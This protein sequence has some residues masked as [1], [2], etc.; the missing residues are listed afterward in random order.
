M[1]YP[2]RVRQ[3]NSNLERLGAIKKSKD[4]QLSEITKAQT[5]KDFE[6]VGKLNSE[7]KKHEDDER[8]EG[9]KVENGLADFESE[10]LTDNK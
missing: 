7:V 8:L 6:K 3:F 2:I 10:R 1:A 4:K 9:N 5:K